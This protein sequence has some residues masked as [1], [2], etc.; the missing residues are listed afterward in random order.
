MKEDKKIKEA[1]WEIEF[2]GNGYNKL[3]GVD[4]QIDNIEFDS[5][6]GQYTYTGIVHRYNE[7]EKTDFACSLQKETVKKKIKEIEER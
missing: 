3:S 4:V 1:I 5:I 7:N 6:T 2:Y